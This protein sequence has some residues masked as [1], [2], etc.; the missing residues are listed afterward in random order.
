M[1]T[2]GYLYDEPELKRQRDRLYQGCAVSG[3]AHPILLISHRI[4]D[5]SLTFGPMMGALGEASLR[6]AEANMEV[7]LEREPECAEAYLLGALPEVGQ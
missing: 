3:G 6:V 4:V 2:G 7:A 1:L 5:I